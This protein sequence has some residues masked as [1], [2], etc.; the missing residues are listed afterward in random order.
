[1][2][3]RNL[4]LWCAYPR[5]LEQKDAAEACVE[6]LSER[7]RATWSRPVSED[8][9]SV[10]LSSRALAR[11]ALSREYPLQPWEWEFVADRRGKPVTRPECGL[12]FSQSSS[13]QLALCLVGER[14]DVGVAAERKSAGRELLRRSKEYFSPIEKGQLFALPGRL[15]CDRALTLWVLKQSYLKARGLGVAL[16]LNKITFLFGGEAGIR[17]LLDPALGAQE[18]SWQFGLVDYAAHRIALMIEGRGSCRL[19][20]LEARPLT[21]APLEVHTGILGWFPWV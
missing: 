17:L 18:G 1:M 2:Q 19:E 11:V 16:P 4:H 8:L 6:M 7:E 9:R 15:K 20:I 12:C 3:V 13:P 14:V 21:G 5:D 10:S